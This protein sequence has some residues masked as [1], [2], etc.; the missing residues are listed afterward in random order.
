M[1]DTLI[2]SSAAVQTHQPP[3]Q[4]SQTQTGL[5]VASVDALTQT[6][7]VVLMESSTQT[8]QAQ[9]QRSFRSGV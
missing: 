4:S 3:L 6:G 7:N 2:S 9:G 5:A 8:P 1:T